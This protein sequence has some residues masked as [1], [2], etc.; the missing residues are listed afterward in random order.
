MVGIAEETVNTSKFFVYYNNDWQ[1]AFVNAQN[2]KGKK[3]QLQLFNI[4]GALLYQSEAPI[5]NGY[6]TSNVNMAAYSSELFI[7]KLTTDKEMLTVK[8]FGGR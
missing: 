8:F 6:F 5:Y 2:L 7:A 4:S 1:T 3:G